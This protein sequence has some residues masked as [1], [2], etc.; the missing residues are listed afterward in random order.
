METEI[1]IKEI[2]KDKPNGTK[3]YADA[4]GKLSLEY[5]NNNGISTKTKI[6]TFRNF[7]NN[8]K[9]DKKWR[10]YFSSF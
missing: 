8:G 5:V 7:Y 2:L 1:N 4:F 9:Y 10:T 3:L 6:G